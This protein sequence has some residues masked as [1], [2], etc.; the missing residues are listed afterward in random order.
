MEH[1]KDTAKAIINCLNEAAENLD[2][3]IVAKLSEGRDRAVM[4]HSARLQTAAST[5]SV[6]LHTLRL[7]NDYIHHHR[8]LVS[9][10]M[11]CSA[12]FVAFV[13]TQEFSGRDAVEQ[14]D[15]FL[16]GAD[17]PPEAFLDK[18]FYTWL[19]HTSGR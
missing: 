19:E 1:E 5:E 13:A 7:F 15:A 2:A 16:L 18:G 10:A 12:V 11:V 17:L 4:A 14:S 8:N 9:T 6:G 3:N